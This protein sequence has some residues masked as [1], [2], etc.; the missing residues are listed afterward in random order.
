MSEQFDVIEQLSTN[1]EADLKSSNN[2]SASTVLN[3]EC[4]SSYYH[5]NIKYGIIYNHIS[6]TCLRC[7]KTSV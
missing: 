1:M 6:K 3:F 4:A 7:T 5:I 2:V